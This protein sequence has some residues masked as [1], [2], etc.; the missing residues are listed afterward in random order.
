MKNIKT[1]IIYFFLLFFL[2]ACGYKKDLV[3]ENEQK[4]G[5]KV[6]KDKVNVSDPLQHY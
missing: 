5:D 2:A 3:K 1:F 4:F 6:N